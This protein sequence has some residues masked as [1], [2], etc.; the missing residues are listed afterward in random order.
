MGR[1]GDGRE[2][3]RCKGIPIAL[4][5]VVVVVASALAFAISGVL[6]QRGFTRAA[7][8]SVLISSGR[9]RRKKSK[10]NEQV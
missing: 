1:V 3:R 4:A 7:C 9:E 2:L 5:L 6:A 10:K 8:N